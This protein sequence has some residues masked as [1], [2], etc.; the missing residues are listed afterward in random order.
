MTTLLLIKGHELNSP[1]PLFLDLFEHRF[2]SEVKL[3][4]STP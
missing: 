4:L 3:S 2:A 1:S